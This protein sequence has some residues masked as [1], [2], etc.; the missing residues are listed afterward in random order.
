MYNVFIIEIMATHLHLDI[1][2]FRRFADKLY[3][4]WQ[5]VASLSDDVI[6]LDLKQLLCLMACFCYKYEI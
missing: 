3:M 2:V 4:M 6:S 1:E 5:F